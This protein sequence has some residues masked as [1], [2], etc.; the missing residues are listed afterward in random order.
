MI[1]DI[2]PPLSSRTAVFPE[3]SPLTREVLLDRARGDHITLSTLRTT[4]HVGAHVDAE[5]HYMDAGA[6]IDQEA[7]D[8]YLGPCLV[9]EV[10]DVGS[11]RI[12]GAHLR[13]LEWDGPPFPRRLLLKSGRF[14]DPECFTDFPG[15]SPGLIRRLASKGVGLLGVDL[16]SVD[17]PDSKTLPAHAA[18]G[19][20]GIRILEGLVLSPITSGHYELIALPL[21]LV[22]FDASPVRAVLRST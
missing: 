7:L 9:V 13:G 4:V 3:D 5:S 20:V 15:V 22:G 18:C 12:E 6:T 21:R 14:P 2:S 19:D 17:P 8:L 1:Y 16:P 11:E 10:E